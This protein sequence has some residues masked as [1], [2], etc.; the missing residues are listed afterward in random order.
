MNAVQLL[1]EQLQSAHVTLEAT[2]ADVTN[3][4]AH[5]RAMGEAIP[6][7]AAYAH[8]ILSEDMVVSM[9]L[10]NKKPIAGD[11]SKTGV[12]KPMPSMK[13]WDKHA[14]WYKT[15]KIDLPKLRTFAKKV[16]K[17]TDVY[18]ATLKEKDLDKKMDLSG[19]GMG[20]QNLAWLISNFVILHIANL[21]GEISAAKGIQGLKGY[22]F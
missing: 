18:L 3:K 20:K 4:T 15:V 12:S 16:Y 8:T 5:F 14:D 7:G 9:M 10:A 17:A 2:M 22:P 19:M 1:R 6:V 21:T 11:N 13:E